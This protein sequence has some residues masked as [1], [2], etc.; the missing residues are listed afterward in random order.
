[1]D[2]ILAAGSPIEKINHQDF[3]FTEGPANDGQGNLYFIDYKQN[4]IVRHDMTAGTFE[5]WAR[6]TEG[7][8]GAKFFRTGQLVSC[9]GRACDVVT[10]TY[11]GR[12]DQV[13]A[14]G[15][16]GKPFNGP[17]DIVISREG[18][19]Y[20]TDPNFEG[21]NHHPEG[22]YSLG[23]DGVL[24]RIDEGIVRPNGILLTPDEKTLIIN[25]TSQR[26]LIAWDVQPDGSVSNRRIWARVRDPNR[27]LYP[28]YPAQNWYGCDGMTVDQDGNLYI[29]MG[30]GVE[31]FDSSG[32]TLGVIPIPQKPTNCCFGGPDRKTLYVTA[33]SSL[34][35]V[36]CRIPG[37]V[38]QQG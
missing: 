4:W 22:V 10:W 30:A 17:N 20:F 37:I 25:G 31:V 29:T 8:N 14:S 32:G 15:Y 19:I 27:Q 1:M 2:R 11:D 26:E 9:R 28:G 13:L 21:R 6:N 24:K 34:Y 16:A 23:P 35:R 7:S 18:W 33:Q 5:V 3:G 38:F 36:R 12:V